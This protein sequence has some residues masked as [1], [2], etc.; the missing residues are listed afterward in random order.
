M[1]RDS[2]NKDS[3]RTTIDKAFGGGGG[4]SKGMI[5]NVLKVLLSAVP[6]LK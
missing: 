1:K 3:K 6:P 2:M 4:V 5:V